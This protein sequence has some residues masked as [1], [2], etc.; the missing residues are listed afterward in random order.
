[1]VFEDGGR[2]KKKRTEGEERRGKEGAKII[3][4]GE[5]ERGSSTYPEKQPVVVMGSESARG[6]SRRLGVGG[7]EWRER[8]RE[9]E[10]QREGELCGGGGWRGRRR[11]DTVAYLI[12]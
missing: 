7:T 12:Q 4:E 8:A 5:K 6:E 2:K 1:M 10:K 3:N 11:T 9:R